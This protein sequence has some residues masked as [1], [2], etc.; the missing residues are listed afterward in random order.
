[1]IRSTAILGLLCAALAAALSPGH[2]ARTAV[3]ARPRAAADGAAAASDRLVLEPVGQLVAKG[4]QI[5]EAL[6]GERMEACPIE[7]AVTGP[8]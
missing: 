8:R 1:M 4:E 6:G 7:H 3:L 5:V 2:D